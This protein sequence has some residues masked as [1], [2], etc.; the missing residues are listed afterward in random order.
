VDADDAK[1]QLS[2]VEDAAPRLRGLE[3]RAVLEQLDQRYPALQVA[4]QWFIDQ[5]RPNESLRFASSLV[6]FWMA[7]KRLGEGSAWLEKVLAL[8]GG[9]DAHRGQALFD[10]GYLAFWSGDDG[11]SS[12]LQGQAL[13]LGRRTN[14]PTVTALSLVGLARIAL[15]TDVEAARRL[16]REALTVTEGTADHV[17][18][19]HAMHVLA[20]AAQMVGDLPEARD[21]MRQRI[22]LARETGNL[23][24]ISIECNNLSMVERQLGNLDAAEALAREALDISHRR[25]DHLAVPWNL[26]GLA[27]AAACR[28]EFER[29]AT[30]IGAADATLEAA[31]GAW[32]PDELAHYQVTVATLGKAMEPPELE[33]ARAAGRSMT[34]LEAVRFALRAESTE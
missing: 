14:H 12:S 9:E 33:A 18:R 2:F 13:E 15:R 1:S 10:A 3:S 29:S 23:A 11:R 28:G 19:S 27:A 31:G 17:G 8:P 4:M 20:V 26:N 6:G 5:R 25:G 7:T 32:P 34:M 24:T 21:R 16:C 30:L 22:A